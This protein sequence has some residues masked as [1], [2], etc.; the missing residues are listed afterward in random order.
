ML[1]LLN[2]T[3]FSVPVAAL[4]LATAALTSRVLGLVRDRIFAGTFGAGEELDVY[5]AA[6]RAPDL[7][8]SIVIGGAISSAFIPVFISHLNRDKREAWEVA[9][10]FFYVAA[11]GLFA[12][13]LLAYIFMPQII[14]FIAPGFSASARTLAVTMSRIMLLSSIFLGLSAVF[15]GVLQSFRKFFIYSLAPIFY[16]LGIILGALFFVDYVGI[17]GLAW[18]VALGAFL[19]ML[20]QVPITV[21]SGFNFMIPRRF[22]HPAVFRILK[23]MVPRTAG[24][25][26]FQIN[27]WVITAIASTLAAGSVSVFNLANNIQYIPIGIVGISFATAAFPALADHISSGD[28]KKYLVEFSRN[29]RHVLFLVMP[30]SVLFFVLRAQIV[31]IVLGTGEFDF[32]DTR[33]TA[34]AL[35]AFSFGIFAYALSPIISRAFY[36]KENT[37]T[38]VVAHVAGIVLNITLSVLFIFVIFPRNGFQEFL[39]SFFKVDDL[40]SSTVIGLPVAFAISGVF[41]LIILLVSFFRERRNRVIAKEIFNAFLRVGLLSMA[42]GFGAWMILRGVEPYVATDTFVGI[43]MQALIAALGAM[44]AYVAVAYILRFPELYSLLSFISRRTGGK[45]LP[46]SAPVHPEGTNGF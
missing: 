38:P 42:V 40:D 8:Y 30:I 20:V 17:I 3:T 15:A 43:F 19:H 12:I 31:R 10:S 14:P 22:F 16:N 9:R 13:G 33:L 26:A 7:I 2:K 39:A 37:L 21:S 27:L 4:I 34:A 24:L 32:E 18:G 45:K 28:Y 36:A 23:L 6:F 5:F 29:I 41:S 1:S 25:A 35:G 11:I 44:A 46:K